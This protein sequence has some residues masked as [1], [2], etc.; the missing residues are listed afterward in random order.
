M[1]RRRPVWSTAGPDCW[2]TAPTAPTPL[3]ADVTA[4]LRDVLGDADTVVRA[5]DPHGEADLVGRLAG[6][7]ARAPGP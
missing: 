3:L 1:P 6:A 7:R 5:V 4:R 2:R